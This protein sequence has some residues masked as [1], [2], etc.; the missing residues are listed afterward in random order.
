MSRFRELTSAEAA[1]GPAVAEWASYGSRHESQFDTV[2]QAVQSLAQGESD[3]ELSAIRVTAGALTI[4]GKR[5]AR[6]LQD[7]RVFPPGFLDY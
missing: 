4:E 6:M 1:R 3:G 7:R 5:L 2:D